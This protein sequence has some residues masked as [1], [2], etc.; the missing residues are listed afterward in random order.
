MKIYT[1]HSL[2]DAGWE[3]A[4][5]SLDTGTEKEWI[6]SD[7][8][9]RFKNPEIVPLSPP[10]TYK[11]F[12]G[13]KYQATRAVVVSW[14][15]DKHRKTRK[16]LFRIVDD[17]PFDVVIG[18]LTLFREDIYIFNEA[19]LL[20]FHRKAK[21]GESHQLFVPRSIIDNVWVCTSTHKF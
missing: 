11:S 4:I 20:F 18:S 16:G 19:A 17:G 6:S 12:Q 9:K 21:D 10:E 7:T 8:L 3:P 5:A 15:T 2:D 14:H 13:L 1:G